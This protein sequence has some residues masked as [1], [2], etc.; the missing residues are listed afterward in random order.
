MVRHLHV[1]RLKVLER[2]PRRWSRH[3]PMSTGFP[4]GADERTERRGHGDERAAGE[5]A[6]AFRS[7]S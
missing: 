1:F 4:V 2:W 3:A 5:F 6:L 7:T